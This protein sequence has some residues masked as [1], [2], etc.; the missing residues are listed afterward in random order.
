M[1]ALERRVTDYWG[2]RSEG[3]FAQRKNE[4]HDAIAGR[5]MQEIR[6]KLPEG[7]ELRILDVGCGTG[8]FS[9][10]LAKEGHSTVGID[11]TPEMVEGAR[12]LCVQEG[13]AAEFLC[14]D[15]Q[16]LTFSDASFDAVISRN[17][18]WT[19]PDAAA[20]YAEWLRV[21]KPGGVLLNFDADYGASLARYPSVE[22]PKNHAHNQIG[23]AMKE[24]S[25]AITRKM[26]IS[27]EKRPL[28]DIGILQ[29]LGASSVE[30]DFCVSERIY[31]KLDEF[32]N[33]V[34][35]FFLTARKRGE[36]TA[37]PSR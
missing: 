29:K 7:R 1:N 30:T 23:A 35:L 31:R 2:K 18:T 22:L 11:L 3:F 8:F 26:A 37:R 5:W 6:A 20:G 32:Y 27:Y 9:I 15:A 10:L 25:D 14:M 19:L 17:L 4:L 12:R 34:P 28:W 36:A 21:L 24:E 13:A 16:D 33:P